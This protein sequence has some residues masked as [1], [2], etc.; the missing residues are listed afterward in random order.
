MG[1]QPPPQKGRRAPQIFGHVYCA[2]TAGWMKNEDGTWYGRRP[3]PRRL[4]VRWG[5]SP[6][7]KGGVAPKFTAHIYCRQMAGWNEDATWYGGRPKP[8]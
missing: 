2:L 8:Q 1:T 3:Q 5:P 4:C 6:S 7:P